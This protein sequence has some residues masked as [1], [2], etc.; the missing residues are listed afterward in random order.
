M[1]SWCD[2]QQ[3]FS[4][5]GAS[6]ILCMR[7]SMLCYEA[8]GIAVCV[9]VGRSLTTAETLPRL[10]RAA[11]PFQPCNVLSF[12][13]LLCGVREVS[14]LPL[15]H[16]QTCQGSL[17]LW[18]LLCALRSGLSCSLHCHVHSASINF[19]RLVSCTLRAGIWVTVVSAGYEASPR[20]NLGSTWSRGG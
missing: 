12:C 2:V 4:C 19:E 16:G 15:A 13:L 9:A 20:P 1:R 17:R 14:R 3:C 18:L 10:G 11:F 8:T 7:L 6:N 5:V